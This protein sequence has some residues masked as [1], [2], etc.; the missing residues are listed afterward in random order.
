MCP[1]AE[2]VLGLPFRLL[3]LTPHPQ[4]CALGPILGRAHGVGPAFLVMVLGP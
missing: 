4:V 2:L 3:H 1:D